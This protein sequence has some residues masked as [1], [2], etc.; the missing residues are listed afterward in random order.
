MKRPFSNSAAPRPDRPWTLPTHQR[1]SR[2]N[3]D[4]LLKIGERVFAMHGFADAHV[5]EIAALAGC[6]IGSFY[7]RFRDKEAL[8]MALQNDMYDQAQNN[9]EKFFE[10]PASGSASLRP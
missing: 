5:S 8:F 9:I 1:R 4:R 3:R 7:R 10:H 2:K 6:S